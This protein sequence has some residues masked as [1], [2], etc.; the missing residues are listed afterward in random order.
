M[1]THI[2]L[3]RMMTSMHL[4]AAL[5]QMQLALNGRGP[6]IV[7]CAEL[8]LIDPC[9]LTLFASALDTVQSQ[10]RRIR[11]DFLGHKISRYL[12]RMDFFE[13]LDIDGVDP[14][15]M[16]RQDQRTNLCELIRLTEEYQ[17]E[18][19]LARMVWAVTGAIGGKTGRDINEPE[20][21]HPINYAL[22]ELV[23]NAVTHAKREGFL[24][25]S[26]WVAAQYYPTPGLVRLA[27]TDNGCGFLNTLRHH[28]SLNEE[29][30][31]AAIAA[32]LKPRVSCNRNLVA[33][34]LSENQGVGLTTTARISKAANGGILIFSGDG[35][36]VDTTATRGQKRWQRQRRLGPS[37]QG[38]G[39]VVDVSRERLASIKIH[40]LLPDDEPMPPDHVNNPP[41]NFV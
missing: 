2:V 13:H 7:D 26:V 30:H 37:W 9:G 21:F 34:G 32:A 19:A 22:S 18:D 31:P 17:A 16:Q 20:L 40:E 3:P 5:G 39:V 33:L 27:V 38:V 15:G 28:P 29:T 25:A 6:L 14:I 1:T 8:T 35:L 36:H 24:G 10:D 11:F 23:G 12:E 41:I 4:E